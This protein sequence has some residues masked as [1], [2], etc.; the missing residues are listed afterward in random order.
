MVLHSPFPPLLARLREEPEDGIEAVFLVGLRAERAGARE[1]A[2]ALL[3]GARRAG[4]AAWVL[5]PYEAPG[6]TAPAFAPW[7]A[8]VAEAQL[9]VR[10]RLGARL[11]A[12]PARG[13]DASR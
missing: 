7:R 4:S 8:G 9:R 12:R 11:G 2:L 13:A 10:V 3:E 1:D 5:A 6:A